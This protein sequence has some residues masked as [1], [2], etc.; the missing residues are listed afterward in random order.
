MKQLGQSKFSAR[1]RFAF[2]PLISHGLL[3]SLLAT[4]AHAQ[5]EPP[6]WRITGL[7]GTARSSHTATLLTDGKVLVVGGVPCCRATG[8]A[9][10]YDPVTGQWNATS[11]PSTPRRSHVAVRLP[12]GKVLIA[13][14]VNDSFTRLNTAEIYDPAPGAWSATGNLSAARQSPR[15]TVLTDGRVL[16]TGGLGTSGTLNTAEL[17]DPA[18]GT[19]SLAGMMNVARISHAMTLL[20]NGQVIAAGGQVVGG[21]S[22]A[23]RTAEIY[24]P[25]AGDWTITGELTVPRPVASS[26]LLGNGKVLVAGGVGLED[27]PLA[28]AELYDPSTGQWSATGNMTTVRFVHTLTLLPAGFVLAAGGSAGGTGFLKSAELYD[29]AT[30]HWT[31]TADLNSG[32]FNHTAT[33]LGDGKVLVAGGFG[34]TP[35]LTSA[36]LY[37]SGADFN[38]DDKLDLV[39]A[40]YLSDDISALIQ[41]QPV[42]YHAEE[43]SNHLHEQLARSE[44]MWRF[45]RGWL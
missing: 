44:R 11:N 7:L 13:G 17:Y 9:E 38:R 31:A 6:I 26:V 12:D 27:N 34:V 1:L 45:Q 42:L 25:A 30:G 16:V 19:W 21:P 2:V 10:V 23:S 22:S 20:P 35:M 41:Q 39:T 14:G 32:R 4:T 37:E 3:I 8:S 24:D 36:E 5:L 43:E 33:L 29:P 28:N 15:A 40:N 18:T